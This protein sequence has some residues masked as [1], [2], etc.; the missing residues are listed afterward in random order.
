MKLE[1]TD[2]ELETTIEALSRWRVYLIAQGQDDTTVNAVLDKLRG[3]SKR[4]Q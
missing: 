2:D 3:R 4:V 1:L